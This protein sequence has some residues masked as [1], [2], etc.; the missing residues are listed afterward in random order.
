MNKP[1]G[2]SSAVFGPD[3]RLLSEDI[4]ETDEGMIYVDLDLDSIIKAKCFIDI[5]GHYSRPDTLWVGVDDREKKHK[6]P[7]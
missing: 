6:R 3:G 5:G 2:G 7:V 1:G 4:V